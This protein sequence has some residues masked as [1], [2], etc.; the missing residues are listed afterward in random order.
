MT[1]GPAPIVPDRRGPRVG[2]ASWWPWFGIF[3]ACVAWSLQE[4]VGYGLSADPCGAASGGGSAGASL[5][6]S[7]ALVLV[8]LCALGAALRTW[9]RSASARERFL[10][11]AGLLLSALFLVALAANLAVLLLVPPCAP[12]AG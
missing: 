8:G 2:G 7:V 4:L 9:R 1:A 3:G 6:V 11:Q 10:G 12:G 5:A